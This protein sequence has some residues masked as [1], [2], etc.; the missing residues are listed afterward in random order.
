MQNATLQGLPVPG[1]NATSNDAS[2]HFSPQLN[3]N[4]AEELKQKASKVAQIGTS[5][6]SSV[7]GVK[8]SA[9][10]IK[11]DLSKSKVELSKMAKC[12]PAQLVG[13][14]AHAPAACTRCGCWSS[15]QSH[16]SRS[17]CRRA[18]G[19]VGGFVAGSVVGYRFG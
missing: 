7:L 14:P 12:A 18:P 19:L 10:S 13:C 16:G 6:M 9:D 2:F 8:P 5:Y 3:I 15:L 4:P 1:A 11:A 17:R